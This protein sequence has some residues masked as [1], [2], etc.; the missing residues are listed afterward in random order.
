MSLPRCGPPDASATMDDDALPATGRIT[1]P[2]KPDRTMRMF[3]WLVAAAAL[4]I[5]VALALARVT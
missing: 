2:T 1:D 5:A 3:E 4:V